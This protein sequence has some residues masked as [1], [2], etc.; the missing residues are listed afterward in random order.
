MEQYQ[1]STKKTENIDL[2]PFL[3][4]QEKKN[5]HVAKFGL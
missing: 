1:I 2:F 4:P 3:Y 5:D